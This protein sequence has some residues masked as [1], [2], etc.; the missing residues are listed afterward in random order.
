ME[1]FNSLR[2]NKKTQIEFDPGFLKFTPLVPFRRIS[3]SLLVTVDDRRRS[4]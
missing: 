2:F 3:R 4:V 1:R